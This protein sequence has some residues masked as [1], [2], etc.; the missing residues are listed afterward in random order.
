MVTMWFDNKYS[1]N[2]VLKTRIRKKL[3]TAKSP[4]QKIEVF[5]SYD[6]GRLLVLDGIVNISGMD[7]FIYHEMMTHV[8]LFTH[9]N[10]EKVLVIGGGD[11]GIVREIAKH[12]SV[13]KI[14]L[15]EIDEQVINASKRY[16][17]G[18][19]VA[20]EDSRLN[21]FV[22]DGSRFLKKCE[23]VYDVIIIDAPD[24]IGTAK[25]LFN[26]S[27]YNHCFRALKKNGLLTTHAETP[28]FKEELKLMKS[29]HSK[30]NTIFPIAHIFTACVPS[31]SIGIWCFIFC[32]KKYH[33]LNDFQEKKLRRLDINCRYYNAEIHQASFSLPNF[34]KAELT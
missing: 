2:T 20:F 28:T 33:P 10:P 15:V 6:F 34:L 21:L 1:Q 3:F 4:Y 9:P 23:E 12:L 7:E 17:P 25:S 30:F 8:P 29:I 14:D 22:E 5:D 16:L 27:F 19:A 24:P 11:G 18:S 13:K 31:Y 26:K 32:S